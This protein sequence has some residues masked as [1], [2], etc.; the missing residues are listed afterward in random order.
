MVLGACRGVEVGQC[1]DSSLVLSVT[2]VSD[3]RFPFAL[4]GGKRI[5]V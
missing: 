5:P 1:P 2:E 4:R 3:K